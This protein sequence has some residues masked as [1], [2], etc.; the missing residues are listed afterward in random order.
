MSLKKINELSLHNKRTQMSYSLIQDLLKQ[1]KTPIRNISYSFQNITYYPDY[2]S[3]WL[4][5]GME[6][7][8]IVMSDKLSNLIYIL[9]VK[10]FQ[11][12]LSWSDEKELEVILT[13]NNQ[14]YKT[15]YQYL[16]YYQD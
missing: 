13:I 14:W 10:N 12:I 9:L 3:K 1:G 15:A 8:L 2:P 11:H 16:K 5:K 6:S 7:S 4:G